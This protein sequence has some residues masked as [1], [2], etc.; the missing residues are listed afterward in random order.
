MLG[1][2]AAL[3]PLDA[4]LPFGK[5][6]LLELLG[7]GG[8]AEV[9]K[10]KL[11]GPGGFS[12][13]VVVKRILPHLAADP[14][15]V[16]MFEREARLS[17]RL[18][19]A[20][21]VQVFEFG[22]SGGEPYL[23]M[24]YV[25]GRDLTQVLRACGDSGRVPPPGLGAYV[26]LEVARAL[27]YAH[28]LRGDDGAPL[29]LVHRDIS[30]SNVLLGADGS[31]KLLDFG[32]AKAFAETEGRTQTGAF[33]GKV[34]YS[35]PEAADGQGIDERADLFALGVV[36]HEALTGR[37][38]FRGESDIQTLGLV[39][40]ARVALPGVSPE[41]DRVC[42]RALARRPEDRYQSAGSM[43]ADLEPVVRKLGFGPTQLAALLPHL[44]LTVSGDDAETSTSLAP[45][46]KRRRWVLLAVG[47]AVLGA[48]SVVLVWPGR[49]A[50]GPPPAQPAPPVVV[51]PAEPEPPPKVALEPPR[52][53]T[54][55]VRVHS[56]PS[57]ATVAAPGSATP[58]GR[59]PLELK[60]SHSERPVRLLVTRP[61]YAPVTL[62]LADVG[63]QQF[64]VQLRRQKAATAPN[65][66]RVANVK[67][68]EVVDPFGR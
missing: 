47:A 42:A 24:E 37:R 39:R 60:W 66:R 4:P 13:A 29:H 9:W 18:S 19:H 64:E 63:I 26:A 31:V 25:P 43:V 54:V 10:A 45:T 44:S 61:G 57:G 35:S 3:M 62:E 8:M 65:K 22:E 56:S 51:A 50:P 49:P 2:A 46:A 15:F 17:S 58:L 28:A 5:Y 27:S 6:R 36:L 33:K 14:Q 48:A 59:T 12:R 23:A 11:D 1:P 41:L 67:D 40:E 20:N 52:I 53:E 68:G 16:K 34:G 21:I 30:P 38:L 55:V 7:R 32:I